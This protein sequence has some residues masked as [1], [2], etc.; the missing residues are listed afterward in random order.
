MLRDLFRVNLYCNNCVI[1]K[2]TLV[3]LLNVIF[4]IYFQSDVE[5][6]FRDSR[7]RYLFTLADGRPICFS[8]AEL[9]NLCSRTIK[10][11]ISGSSGFYGQFSED[12]RTILFDCAT[13]F[14][15]RYRSGKHLL[16]VAAQQKKAA[17][18]KEKAER[19]TDLLQMRL[20]DYEKLG[21]GA[22]ASRRTTE[23]LIISKEQVSNP[24]S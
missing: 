17:K 22:K 5:F 12:Q 16:K 15:N 4:V 10:N 7:K 11:T 23:E 21:V 8:P 18:L 2:N 1:V 13:R 3:S 14:D 19:A 20:E 24:I 9:A 6:E